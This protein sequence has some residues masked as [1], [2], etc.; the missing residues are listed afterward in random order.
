MTGIVRF[1]LGIQRNSKFFGHRIFFQV[2]TRIKK[3]SY[4]STYERDLLVGAHRRKKAQETPEGSANGPAQSGEPTWAF[5]FC[6]L[7]SLFLRKLAV[8]CFSP[9][10]P[11]RVFSKN[12]RCVFLKSFMCI[13]KLSAYKKFSLYK[14]MFSVH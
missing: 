2:V 1:N 11:F 8:G 9:W 13:K 4:W 3:F 10:F 6:F 12:V 14:K 5:F 7:F